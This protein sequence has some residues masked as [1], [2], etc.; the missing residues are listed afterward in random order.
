MNTVKLRYIC[1]YKSHYSHYLIFQTDR[2]DA[3]CA[4]YSNIIDS[5]TKLISAVDDF[6]IDDQ[7]GKTTTATNQNNNELEKAKTTVFAYAETLQKSPVQ[8]ERN[9]PQSCPSLDALIDS[10][11]TTAAKVSECQTSEDIFQRSSMS[12]MGSLDAICPNPEVVNS[13]KLLWSHPTIQK[14]YER[15]NEF[16]LIDSA[17]YFLNAL[18][19]ICATDYDPT[20]DDVLR[21]RVRTCGIYKIEF[22]FR[23]LMVNNCAKK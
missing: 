4:V 18:D 13:I 11:G 14:A 21:T 2:Y 1:I 17:A 12:N 23:H 19:R 15:R 16:Q 3:R 5:V 9:P 6:N 10:S 7:G 8:K 20:D 22:E